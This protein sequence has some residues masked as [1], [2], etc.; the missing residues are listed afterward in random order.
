LDILHVSH[1]SGQFCFTLGGA[2]TFNKGWSFIK[3]I[4]TFCM[5]YQFKTP[6]A[7]HLNSSLMNGNFK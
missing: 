5:C 7:C 2:K 3:C 1:P 4:F 6:K